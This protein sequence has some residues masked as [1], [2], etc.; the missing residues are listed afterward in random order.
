MLTLFAIPKPFADKH[1]NMIQR[2]AIKSWTFLRPD[3]EIILF[4]KE[5]GVAEVAKEFNVKHIPDIPC[6]KFGTPLWS[7]AFDLARKESKKDILAYVESD[8]ILT[9]DFIKAI[10]KIDKHLFLMLGQR[11]DLDI[12]EP[13]DFSNSDWQKKITKLAKD[14]GRLH[15]QSGM[16]Y[17][18][19]PAKFKFQLPPFPVGRPL[20]DNWFVYKA[21]SLKV[22]VIDATEIVLDIHQNH[23]YSHH[24]QGKK[25]IWEGEE[26]QEN[27]KLVGGYSYVF[28]IYNVDFRLTDK[29]LKRPKLTIP[30]VREY[31]WALSVLHPKF[32]ILFKLIS[33]LFQ[34]KRAAGLLLKKIMKTL[35]N[36]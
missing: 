30:Y 6:N 7:S 23:G 25:G 14:R 9:S 33:F 28:T 11:T 10:L 16:D 32:S 27:L 29:G 20:H 24:P 4:G 21:R 8:N 22:P 17:F 5:Q 36:G 34:P 15:G 2:N 18:V 3:I 12:H 26:A 19:F 13:I 1:I 31:F 35:K